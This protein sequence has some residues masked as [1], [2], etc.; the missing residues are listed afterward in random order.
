MH[1]EAGTGDAVR[2]GN[3]HLFPIAVSIKHINEIFSINQIMMLLS[4]YGYL[5]VQSSSL[6]GFTCDID[7]SSKGKG[8]LPHAQN[9]N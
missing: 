9:T 2:K 3:R 5:Q 7:F 8:S 6:P 4:L 1:Q